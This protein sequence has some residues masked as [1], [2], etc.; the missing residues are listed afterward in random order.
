MRPIEEIASGLGLG[1]EEWEPY[2]RYVAKV[3][4]A[5]AKDLEIAR[6]DF[7]WRVFKVK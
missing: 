4:P 7:R 3:D 2:G 1:A 5:Q 6:A